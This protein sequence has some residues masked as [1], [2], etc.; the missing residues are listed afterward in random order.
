[1]VLTTSGSFIGSAACGLAAAFEGSRAP[2]RVPGPGEAKKRRKHRLNPLRLVLNLGGR[3]AETVGVNL[4]H[5]ERIGPVRPEKRGG[6]RLDGSAGERLV[7]SCLRVIRG[8][9]SRR[10]FAALQ[11]EH[12]ARVFQR[13]A[14]P[15]ERGRAGW[16]GWGTPSG[17][18]DSF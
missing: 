14:R 17:L 16:T 15:G 2:G 1:V 6:G 4:H 12:L 7:F 18:A 10:Q 5:T 11:V 8:G 9:V 3:P 13:S